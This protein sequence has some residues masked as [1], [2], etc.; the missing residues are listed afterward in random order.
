MLSQNLAFGRALRSLRK[1]RKTTQRDLAVFARLDR[2]YISTLEL[3]ESSPT[4][5][6]MLALCR[7]LD[8]TL[9]DLAAAI[10]H[11]LGSRR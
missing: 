8:I 3:G 2:S 11:E 5:D 1:A 4:L 9:T 6:T 7:A 10:E